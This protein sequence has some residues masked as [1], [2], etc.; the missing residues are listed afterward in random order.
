MRSDI[1]SFRVMVDVIKERQRQ[2]EKWGVQNHSPAEW[3]LIL[4]EEVGEFSQAVLDNQA[5]GA[6]PSHIR[7]ELVQFTA[8]ALSMLECCDRNG[9]S[10]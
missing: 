1:T 2:D 8:V 7:T 10:E 3:M 9:W 5:L 6:D 4:M